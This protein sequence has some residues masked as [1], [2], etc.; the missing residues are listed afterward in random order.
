MNNLR[1]SREEKTISVSHERCIIILHISREEKT[2]SAINHVR[3]RQVVYLMKGMNN[4]HISCKE[5]TISD[6]H[7]RDEQPSYL[8]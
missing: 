3:K 1:I 8:I 2:L 4:L 5:K 6:S 7:E